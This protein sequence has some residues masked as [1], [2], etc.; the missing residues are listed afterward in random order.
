MS[1][2]TPRVLAVSFTARLGKPAAVGTLVL[3]NVETALRFMV[4]PCFLLLFVEI[5]GVM[6]DRIQAFLSLRMD[7]R[8]ALQVWIPV[9]A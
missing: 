5:D 2:S 1:P 4:L 9:E 6:A 7:V 8:V 3:G